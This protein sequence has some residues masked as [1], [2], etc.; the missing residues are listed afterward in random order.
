MNLIF[1]TN[2]IPYP[3]D[4]GE[5]IRSYNLLK[6]AASFARVSLY[7]L[8]QDSKEEPAARAELERFC[9][10]V[11]FYPVSKYASM[12]RM[13]FSLL[14]GGPLTFAHFHSAAMLSD[15]KRAALSGKADA[16]FAYCSSSARYAFGIE[17]VPRI[18]DFVDVDSFK[19]EEYSRLSRFPLSAVYGIEAARLRKAERAMIADFDLSVVTTEK[20]RKN[21]ISLVPAAEDRCRTLQS[22]VDTGF[23]GRPD[24]GCPGKEE[25]SLVFTGQMDYMPNVDAAVYFYNEVLPLVKKRFPGAKFYIVGRNPAPRLA[26]ECP[27]AVITGGVPD[28]RPYL[29][30]AS[31]Y[32]APLRISY[33]VPNKILEAMAAGVPVAATAR[34]VQGIGALPGRDVLTSDTPG[35][36]ADNVISLFKDAGLRE[37]VSKNAKEYVMREHDWPC[38]AEKFRDMVAGVRKARRRC[39]AT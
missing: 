22:G 24:E 34:A 29:W 23:F 5:R 33:G 4:K 21:L 3:P 7:S 2:K 13:G 9:E 8:S 35:G 12:I 16:V 14:A 18:V 30:R 11:S 20:E 26:S 6:A 28:I 36:M 32:V 19:W 37:S 25:G 15:I 38:T 10:K 1:I 17:S 31:V 27:G 39:V